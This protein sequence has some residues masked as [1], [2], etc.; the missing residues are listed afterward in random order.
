[1]VYQLVE[2]EGPLVSP[3][4]DVGQFNQILRMGIQQRKLHI[5]PVGHSCR[6]FVLMNQTQCA[7]HIGQGF[8]SSMSEITMGCCVLIG[9]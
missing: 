1:V 8:V 5:E 7:T 2:P 6:R 9:Q 4:H 3:S